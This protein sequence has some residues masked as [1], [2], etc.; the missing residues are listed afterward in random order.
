MKKY[1]SFILALI[2][3]L[4]CLSGCQSESSADSQQK[5]EAVFHDF[6]AKD[7]D[8]NIVTE[9]ILE[10]KKLTM[11]NIWATFCGPCIRE[12]P[13]LAK[14]SEEWEG[15]MQVIGIV[16]DLCDRNGNVLPDKKAEAL[17]II[18]ETGADYL[19]LAPSDSL[20]NAYLNG[21]M[22]VPETLFVDSEGYILGE[23]YMG[24]RSETEW[25]SII[26]SYLEK[27]Q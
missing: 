4:L 26:E 24:A 7:L 21:V 27:K 6:A 2:L 16:L 19:H 3:P 12:M 8:G 10:E 9:S 14:L 1:L 15:E 17:N 11:I 20:N 5:V 13:A 23:S 25:R 18:G 22:S